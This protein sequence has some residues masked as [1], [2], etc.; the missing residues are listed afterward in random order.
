MKGPNRIFMID[1]N[2]GE[3]EIIIPPLGDYGMRGV[4]RQNMIMF[5][6]NKVKN[7]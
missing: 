1:R 2:N 5:Q 4:N 7:N 6:S 3:V